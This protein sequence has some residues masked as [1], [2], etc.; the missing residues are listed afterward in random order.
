[1]TVVADA[2]DFSSIQIL[3]SPD[4]HNWPVTTAITR[5]EFRANDFRIDFTKKHG[6]GRWPDAVTPG[7]DGPLQ[8]TIWVVLPAQKLTCGCIQMW[9]GKEE[10]Q[11]IG[12]GGPFSKGAQDWWFRVGPMAGIQPQA[13]D[14]V[15]F[16]V[17]AGDARLRT[18][19]TSVHERSNIV[20]VTIPSNDSGV[21][22]F[23]STATEPAHAPDVTPEPPQ[24]DDA[25]G[26]AAT[27]APAVL[28]RI[29]KLE[30]ELKGAVKVL[31]ERLKR[32]EQ[33]PFPI[34]VAADGSRMVPE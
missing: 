25:T 1:M 33:R 31:E 34:Y 18:D 10:N 16:F 21:F 32:I 26:T 9:H 15:G 28:A 19:P 24:P 4:V 13:G 12:V 11:G 27:D 23:P 7:W 5:I 2:L 20:V 17:T 29:D 6:P 22:T 8:Y 3:Q 14:R 30:R